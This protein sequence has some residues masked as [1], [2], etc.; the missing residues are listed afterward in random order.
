LDLE[1]IKVGFRLRAVKK[2]L[3]RRSIFIVGSLSLRSVYVKR[4][5][6]FSRTEAAA[7]GMGFLV[8]MNMDI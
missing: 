1:K 6:A 7:A 3:Q 2:K 4:R 8:D 5:V